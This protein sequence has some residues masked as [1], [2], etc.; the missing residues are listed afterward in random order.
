MPFNYTLLVPLP[1]SS[2]DGHHISHTTIIPVCA[3]K[4]PFSEELVITWRAAKSA[5]FACDQPRKADW[6]VIF[7]IGADGLQADRQTC[8]GH[9][10]RECRGRLPGQGGDPRVGALPGVGNGHAI[11]RERTL[12][13]W[14][15][16]VRKSR[17]DVCGGE[18]HIPL[19]KERSP[20]CTIGFTLA[21]PDDVV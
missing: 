20:Q 4:A 3:A 17:H 14:G 18:H 19:A 5:Q 21:M 13:K 12:L 2:K 9:A 1:S 16:G 8:V 15:V 10:N 6:S 7:Q 11:D